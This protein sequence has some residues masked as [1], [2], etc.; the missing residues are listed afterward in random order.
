MRRRRKQMAD[1]GDAVNV[2]PMLDIVFI[3]LIFFI[4]T[5]TFLNETGLDFTQPRDSGGDSTGDPKPV[6]AVYVD[7]QSLCSV[8]GEPRE[9]TEVD[10]AV[11]GH[12]ANKPGATVSIQV[13]YASDHKIQV[14]LKDRFK[15]R[16]QKTKIEYV[17]KGI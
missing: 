13:H 1:D 3:M 17:G 10:I 4:V 8:E 16:N 11:E 2:T 7:E 6:I 9:C 14:L 5:A 12:L 15:K